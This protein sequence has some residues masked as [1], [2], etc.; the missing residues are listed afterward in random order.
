M[1]ALEKVERFASKGRKSTKTSTES[2]HKQKFMRI[3]KSTFQLQ[4]N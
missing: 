3:G 1:T 2:R 4:T